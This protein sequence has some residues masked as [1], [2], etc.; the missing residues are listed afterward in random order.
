MENNP[1]SEYGTTDHQPL[2]KNMCRP[3]RWTEHD[4]SCSWFVSFMKGIVLGHKLV[5]VI[6][7]DSTNSTMVCGVQIVCL[8]FFD[9]ERV[10]MQ[11]ILAFSVTFTSVNMWRL[12]AFVSV[13]E[14]PPSTNKQDCWHVVL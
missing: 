14:K 7:N 9:I 12:V 4:V 8:Y 1:A 6:K 10:C 13:K 3:Q 11:P 2:G 5:K